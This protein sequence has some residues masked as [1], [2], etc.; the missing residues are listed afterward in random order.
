MA[1]SIARHWSLGGSGLSLDQVVEHV[2][3]LAW[4]GLRAPQRAGD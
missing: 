2:S 1:E 3:D 4:H